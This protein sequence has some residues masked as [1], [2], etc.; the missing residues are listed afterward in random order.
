MPRALAS[1]TLPV[2]LA[3]VVH[4][5]SSP[6]TLFHRQFAASAR[7]LEDEK[8]QHSFKT[9]LFDSTHQRLKRERAEHD[10]FSHQQQMS[11]GGR[12]AAL[13]FGMQLNRLTATSATC[14]LI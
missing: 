7:R 1:S 6:V 2:R 3:R 9:Q 11:P 4:R 8:P 12:Y 10:R 13:M 14:V 5:K